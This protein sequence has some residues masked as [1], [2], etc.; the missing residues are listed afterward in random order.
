MPDALNRIL[1]G[2]RAG[3]PSPSEPPAV[4]E[5]RA[6]VAAGDTAGARAIRDRLTADRAAAEGALH[7]AIVGLHDAERRHREAVVAADEAERWA[8]VADAI[9]GQS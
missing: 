8:L 5:L 9:A 2:A 3:N 1:A 4:R 6:L 7:E